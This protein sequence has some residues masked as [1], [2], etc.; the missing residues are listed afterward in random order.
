MNPERIVT[1]VLFC[2]IAK[3]KFD[4]NFDDLHVDRLW[5]FLKSPQQGIRLLV[6]ELLNEEELKY[7]DSAM[8]IAH[9]EVVK[10]LEKKYVTK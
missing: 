7:L 2:L 6:V 5:Q 4:W 8:D 1:C 9:F 10:S 3:G